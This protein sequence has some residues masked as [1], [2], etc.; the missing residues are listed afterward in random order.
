MEEELSRLRAGVDDRKDKTQKPAD[1]NQIL[2]MYIVAAQAAT[3]ATARVHSEDR[4]RD[5]ERFNRIIDGFNC[6]VDGIS[7][8]A[9]EIRAILSI[10]RARLIRQCSKKESIAQRF[11]WITNTFL[12]APLTAIVIIKLSPDVILCS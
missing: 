9:G 6:M 4:R 10:T 3:Q 11:D 5:D 1:D 12:H 2:A 7:G 8:L